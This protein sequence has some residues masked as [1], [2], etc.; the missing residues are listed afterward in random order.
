MVIKNLCI[1]VLLTK[2]A[3]ALEGLDLGVSIVIKLCFR[4]I[5]LYYFILQ[6]STSKSSS[7]SGSSAHLNTT[8]HLKHSLGAA[9]P[10]AGQNMN[11]STHIA[12][13][14]GLS[15]HTSVSTK[16]PSIRSHFD[17]VNKENASCNQG[18]DDNGGDLPK[19]PRR[20]G[21]LNGSPD[22]FK[23]SSSEKSS[24]QSGDEAPRGRANAGDGSQSTGNDSKANTVGMNT[25][26]VAEPQGRH[27]YNLTV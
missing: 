23:D 20:S 2:V 25:K 7:T 8:S 19:E 14:S 15:G 9:L 3:L 22:L 26:S 24:S 5:D 12:S 6:K 27:T 13:T 21:D 10:S 16:P 11:Q 4:K 18:T 17:K 1:L